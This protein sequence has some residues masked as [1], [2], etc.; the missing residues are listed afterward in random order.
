MPRKKKSAP[1][2]TERLWRD[3]DLDRL[4]GELKRGAPLTDIA[5]LLDRD[6]FEIETMA[7]AFFTSAVSATDDTCQVAL[8][9]E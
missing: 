6:A 8:R 4:R 9:N 7:E 1:K 3:V 2:T 5:E